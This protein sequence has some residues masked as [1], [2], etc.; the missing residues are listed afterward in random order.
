MAEAYKAILENEEQLNNIAREA[1]NN[2]NTNQNGKI[3]K[4]QLESMMN[5]VYSDI[6][7]ELPSKSKVDDVF[8]YLDSK[9]KGYISFEDFKVL[10]KDVIKSMIEALS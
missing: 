9:Q 10:V 8:D 4:S 1:F 2:V 5:Q 7:H 6:F 3:D